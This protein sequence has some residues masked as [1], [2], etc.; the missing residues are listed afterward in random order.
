[1]NIKL[2]PEQEK[3]IEIQ[4][5]SGNFATFEEVI[6]KAFKLLEYQ[7]WMEE[8]PEKIDSGVAELDRREGLD[9]EAVVM[10]ILNSRVGWVEER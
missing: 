4:V 3:F 10:D 8:T 6:D 5:N 1:M 9:G 2:T 7:Q